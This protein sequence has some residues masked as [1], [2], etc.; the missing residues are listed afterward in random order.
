MRD[1]NTAI[2]LRKLGTAIRRRRHSLRLSQAQAAYRAG[3]HR[4]Y[5]S[6][7]ERGE[8]NPSF[9]TLL[10]VERGLD[11]PLE[12]LLSGARRAHA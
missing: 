6:A 7:L 11:I 5:V 10:R 4:G 2:T 1:S 8:V 9:E 3:I 12:R